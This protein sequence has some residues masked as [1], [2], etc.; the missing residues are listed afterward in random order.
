[1]YIYERIDRQEF[2][3]NGKISKIQTRVASHLCTCI[4]TD[5]N[6]MTQRESARAR[7]RE[8]ERARASEGDV[9]NLKVIYKY[10]YI[11]AQVREIYTI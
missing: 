3:G 9:Y 10:V 1:M 6:T 11:R 7:A 8:R 2:R 5:K 4:K